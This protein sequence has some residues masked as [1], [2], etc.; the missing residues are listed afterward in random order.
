MSFVNVNVAS[1]GV[2][3][4]TSNS[5]AGTTAY[6]N[7]LGS[8][9]GTRTAA[10]FNIPAGGATVLTPTANDGIAFG[11]TAGVNGI[12]GSGKITKTGSG[13]L[14]IPYLNVTEAISYTNWT[15]GLDVQGGTIG[16][17]FNNNA[18]GNKLFGT[19]PISFSAGTGLFN[20]QSVQGYGIGNAININGSCDLNSIA[21]RGTIQLTGAIAVNGAYTITTSSPVTIS[22]GATLTGTSGFTKA[23]AGLLT[24]GVSSTISG[25]VSISSGSS[26]TVSTALGLQNITFDPSGAGT[27]T[28]PVSA[29]LGGLTGSGSFGG[30]GATTMLTLGGGTVDVS[31]IWT[32]NFTANTPLTKSAPAGGTGVLQLSGVSDRTTATTTISLGAIQLNSA[33]GL[34]A[35]GASNTTTVSSGGGL[36]LNGITTNTSSQANISGNGVALNGA[37]RNFGGN[38]TH[39]ATITLGASSR[40]FNDV[41]STTMTLKN[42]SIGANTLTLDTGATSSASLLMDGTSNSASAGAIVLVTGAGVTK[43]PRSTTI[44]SAAILTVDTGGSIQFTAAGATVA[45]VTTLK[46]NAGAGARTIII[47]S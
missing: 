15:G 25:T 16:S 12:N 27:L 39:T 30:A 44:P 14:Y 41:A 11:F 6:W 4:I 13:F 2:A 35:S 33:T 17:Q 32:G 9:L 26:L 5:G 18:T 23:G 22:T 34:Y 8:A 46:G 19:G 24:I 38:S 36:W 21:S 42:V 40:I 20:G 1:I 47:G 31:S 3:S 28:L 10:T 7:L 45:T 43:A 37:L 29:T